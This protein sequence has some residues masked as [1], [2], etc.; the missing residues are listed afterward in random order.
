MVTTLPAWLHRA[1][2]RAVDLFFPARCLSCGSDLLLQGGAPDRCPGEVNLCTSCIDN[3]EVPGRS[4]QAENVCRQCAARIPAILGIDCPHCN[5]NKYCFDQ[6]VAL[7]PYEGRLRKLV[8]RMKQDRTETIAQAL[9]QLLCQRLPPLQN[10]EPWNL[11]VPIPMHPW[12]QVIRGTNGPAILARIVGSHLGLPVLDRVLRPSRNSSPQKGLSRKSRFR[13]MRGGVVLQAG[14][15]IEAA[16]VLLVDDILTTGATCSEAAR[17]L[18]Q[19][20][21]AQVTVA[22]IART[23][24]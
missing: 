23:V 20:G 9:G 19:A 3:L 12:R 21:A 14:Y 17:I 18:K 24:G 7:G 22:V 2:G 15:P 5:R 1:K 8:L 4:Q 11:V 13:N 6:A 10:S 16:K